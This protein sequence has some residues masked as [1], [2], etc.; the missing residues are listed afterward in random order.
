MATQQFAINATTGN[1]VPVPA[2]RDRRGLYL[3][4][5][6][7][8]SATMWVAFGQPA[9][10]GTNGELEIPPGS[11]YSFGGELKPSTRTLPGSFYLP[12]CPPE[13]INVICSATASGCAMTQ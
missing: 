2:D 11:E 5:Y 1:S 4:N 10:L 13:S 6:S 3:R 8:S 7:N 9:T 12:N